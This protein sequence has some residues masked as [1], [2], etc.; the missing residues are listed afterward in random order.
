MYGFGKA[1]LLNVIIHRLYISAMVYF[2]TLTASFTSAIFA[3][4]TASASKAFGVGSEVGTLGTTLYVLGFAFGPF[5]CAPAS[6][7][8]GRWWPLTVGM[9]GGAIFTIAS[10]V[11]KDIQTLII[12]RFFAGVSGAS[13]LSVVP[14]VLSDIYSNTH[15]G[16]AI[17]YY[18][19]TVFIGPFS[20]PSIGGFISTS[21]LGWRWTLYIPSFMSF[22][23]G[24]LF[25]CF[26]KKTYAP[27]LLVSKAAAM[28]R[29]TSNWGIHAKQDTLEVNIGELLQKYFS[30]PIYMLVTEP[31]ILLISLYMSFIYGIVYA[32][33]EAYPFVFESVYGMSRGIAGLAFIGLTIGQLLPCG[34]IV[35]RHSDYARKLAAND[36]VPIPEWRLLP[37]T[38]GAP[39]FTVG[40]FW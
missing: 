22:I 5:I 16:A 19:L 17:S 35:S 28:R 37:A 29:Q 10:A 7:L 2:G 13:Q 27:V 21:S 33:L 34:F 6:V 32:L 4:G 36:N 12:C 25:I 8:I 11:A 24:S 18:A 14:A 9:L 26:L 23:C 39:I 1:P 15:R 20:A 30:R 38:V 40:L 3:P 31:V